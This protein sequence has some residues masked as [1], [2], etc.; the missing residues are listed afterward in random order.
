LEESVGKGNQQ[1]CQENGSDI[2][3]GQPDASEWQKTMVHLLRHQIILLAMKH[4]RAPLSVS[5]AL[6]KGLARL[7]ALN[8]LYDLGSIARRLYFLG[9][10]R[11]LLAELKA[12]TG[13]RSFVEEPEA[14][15][16]GIAPEHRHKY[17]DESRYQ[18]DQ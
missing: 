5:H 4:G 17:E 1:S 8:D 3:D 9:D 18:W 15:R 2:R 12:R 10:G 7:G 16:I 13:A 14:S 11:I 6:W